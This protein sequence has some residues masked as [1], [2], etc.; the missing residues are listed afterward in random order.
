MGEVVPRECITNALPADDCLGTLLSLEHSLGQCA[1][2]AL[3]QVLVVE[4]TVEVSAP[5]VELLGE[6]K[7]RGRRGGKEAGLLL[8]QRLGALAGACATVGSAHGARVLALKPR[9]PGS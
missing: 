6:E 1:S 8:H 3:W 4:H 7:G 2:E 9:H 5:I